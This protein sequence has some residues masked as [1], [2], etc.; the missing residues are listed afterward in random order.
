ME[1]SNDKLP[2]KYSMSL[3]AELLTN[4][5]NS[6]VSIRNTPI[7]TDADVAFLYGVETRRINEAV[8]NNPDKLPEDYMS[9]LTAEGLIDLRS[10]FSATKVSPKSRVS[11]KA[12]TENGIHIRIEL[13]HWK[14]QTH[15][16]TNKTS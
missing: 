10:K 12:F 4:V 13:F 3:N 9:T 5:R 11:P 7:I 15:G 1:N 16:K 6:I 2:T 14:N 8:R